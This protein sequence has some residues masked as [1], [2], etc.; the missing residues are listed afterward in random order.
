VVLKSLDRGPRR[1]PE[2][3]DLVDRRG[4][5]PD[6]RQASLDV[7]DGGAAVADREGQG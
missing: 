1:G 2:D 6:G 7:T 4:P 3:T 5:R